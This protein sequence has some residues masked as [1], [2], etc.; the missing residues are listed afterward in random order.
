VSRRA[1]ARAPIAVLAALAFL[2]AALGPA[3]AVSP[4][5]EPA[6]QLGCFARP[7]AAWQRPFACREQAALAVAG[8]DVLSPDG[9]FDLHPDTEID[10][11]LDVF[12]RDPLSGRLTYVG[13]LRDA[14]LDLPSCPPGVVQGLAPGL[15]A[16]AAFAL[17][18]DGRE[19]F[20]SSSESSSLTWLIRDPASGA[21]RAGGCVRAGGATP[22]AVSC[23][24]LEPRLRS[25]QA[26]ATSPDGRSLYVAV[27]GGILTFAR[28]PATG[29]LRYASCIEAPGPAGAGCA[30]APALGGA[31]DG[32]AVSRDGRLVLAIDPDAASL[33]AL[34]RDPATG[35]L[36]FAS[37]VDD[38]GDVATRGQCRRGRSSGLAFGLDGD[39]S[40]LAL[41][42][43]GRSAYVVGVDDDV[44]SAF[45]VDPRT[46]ALRFGGCLRDAA[47]PLRG[48]CGRALPTH[49]RAP[50]LQAPQAVAV[51]PD[52]RWVYVALQDGIVVSAFAR[53]PGG[54]LRFASCA[55]EHAAGRPPQRCGVA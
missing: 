15:D 40:G 11:E 22:F 31:P 17:T 55:L 20:V 4:A 14:A 9:R 26:L 28:D 51:S 47:E 23:A 2:A 37:C 32:L 21:L 52:D 44:V 16:G 48:A 30:R 33:V 54:A 12:A 46:G 5:A 42:G 10:H 3:A 7:D 49:G 45:A 27:A 38:P 18:G 29:A 41:S 43:D 39:I 34:R 19:A 50:G 25:P 36:R 13:C 1:L 53:G 24:T 6:S 8:G 35:A